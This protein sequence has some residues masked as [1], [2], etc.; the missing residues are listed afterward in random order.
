MFKPAWM[1][2]QTKEGEYSY[3]DREFFK[4]R[5]FLRWDITMDHTDAAMVIRLLRLVMQGPVT[6]LVMACLLSS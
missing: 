5:G 6:A 4:E 3:N 1:N 2:S